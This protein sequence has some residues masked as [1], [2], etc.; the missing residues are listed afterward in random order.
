MT[1]AVF[2]LGV[3]WIVQV[4]VTMCISDDRRLL[5][6]DVERRKGLE[7]A[8]ARDFERMRAELEQTRRERDKYRDLQTSAAIKLSRITAIVNAKGKE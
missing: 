5:S 2:F 3:A 8:W 7:T 6:E 4:V 1:F